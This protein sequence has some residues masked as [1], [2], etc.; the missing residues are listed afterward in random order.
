[1][2]TI[3]ELQAELKALECKPIIERLLRIRDGMKVNVGK[4]FSTH[5]LSRDVVYKKKGEIN[6]SV[7]ISIIK[8]IGIKYGSGPWASELYDEEA[9]YRLEKPILE[10]YNVF[11]EVDSIQITLNNKYE[12]YSIR[13]R[14]KSY[15]RNLYRYEQKPEVFDNFRAIIENTIDGLLSTSVDL[16]NNAPMDF[17]S[18]CNL[19]GCT[20]KESLESI[21][22][23]IMKLDETE[24]YYLTD[25]HPF[26]YRDFGILASKESCLLI[27]NKIK[28]HEKKIRRATSFSCGGEYI[29]AYELSEYDRRHV[30][31]LTGILNKLNNEISNRSNPE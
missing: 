24:Y 1:M 11:Y 26:L 10:Q 9:L 23:K 18:H 8:V 17:H 19:D 3:E 20:V 28:E 21:G 25:W 6:T 5:S 2:K 7:N 13:S 22:C 29:S 31:V 12:G 4:V 16:L 27:E 15:T 30:R 14:E